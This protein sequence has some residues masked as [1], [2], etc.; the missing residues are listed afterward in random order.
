M[1]VTLPNGVVINGVPDNATKEE[2]RQKAIAAGLATEADFPAPEV[3]TSVP[4]NVGFQPTEVP[5]KRGFMQGI[6]DFIAGGPEGQRNVF[7]APEL[8]EMSW[9]AAKSGLGGLLTGDPAEIQQIIAT[10]YPEAEFG[11]I[12]GQM[13][14]RFPSGDYLLQPEGIDPLDVARFG[15]DVAAF[16]P[17]GGVIGTG[18][19]QLAKGAAVAGGTQSALQGVE[20][21]TGGTF[22]P[23]DVAI[24]AATQGALQMAEPV[25][26]A[27]AGAIKSKVSPLID[28]FTQR[29]G[30]SGDASYSD[31]A[32]SLTGNAE[33]VMPDIMADPEV[34]AAANDLGINVNPSVYS[35]SDIY[36]EM[37]NAL[38]AIPGSQLSANEKETVRQLGIAA[39]DLVRQWAGT[40]DKSQI[41]AEF[42]DK[43]LNTINQ[44]DQE[45]SAIYSALEEVI[46][47]SM[48]M[49]ATST[50]D[51]INEF[52]AELGGVENLDPM[53]ARLYKQLTE[54]EGGPTYALVD[55][56]RRDVGSALKG[57][58]PF[59]DGSQYELKRI[60]GTL[61][62]DALRPAELFG[63]SEEAQ[64]AKDLVRQRKAM[65]ETLQGALG[66]DLSKSLMTEITSGVRGLAKGTTG[67]FNKV[68][69]AVPMEDREMV[70]TAALNDLFAGG[71]TRSKDFSLGGFVGNYEALL[72]NRAAANELF[73]YVPQEAQ[74]RL[75]SIYRVSKGLMEAN[76]KDLNNPSGTARA[77]IGA[78]DAPDGII[79][80]LFKVGRQVGAGAAATSPFD[81]GIVGA[82][83][84]FLNAMRA[85]K[86]KATE[87]ATEM[88]TNPGFQD[89]MQRFIAG[90]TQSANTLLNSLTA[91]KTWL[92]NQPAEVKR[93]IARQGLIQ[94]LMSEEE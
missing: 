73:Q 94:Y 10:N 44:M 39:D 37:E 34:L 92:A 50:V 74:D 75:K 93:A 57:S 38:K 32:K 87:A 8:N 22:D 91:T 90:D 35:T 36:R 48:K 17:A 63:L 70:A 88:L 84:G 72:R 69:E 49:Q 6:K 85:T 60:Y 11:D 4:R 29:F 67:R 76:K 42:T 89:A 68:M 1:N 21:A 81:A 55:K 27:G 2:V 28:K 14:V 43:M 40:T 9:R 30:R 82:T 25:V 66:R 64:L 80:K 79:S 53:V 51:L 45:S 7:A 59:K 52:A 65:E 61:S 54:Q 86:T 47:R 56:L 18:A 3:D 5:E 77:V 83:G 15:T 19:R 31:V 26:R 12:G 13:A 46:P 41:S 33:D 71:S 24:E 62:D 16:V 78:M 58:G 23:E 20:A